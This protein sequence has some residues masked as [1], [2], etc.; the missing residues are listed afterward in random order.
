MGS[1]GN[2]LAPSYVPDKL[3]SIVCQFPAFPTESMPDP[4]NFSQV[5]N[6]SSRRF[7]CVDPMVEEKY[8]KNLRLTFS[9]HNFSELRP[10][11]AVLIPNYMIWGIEYYRN[12]N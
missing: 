2:K 7:V 4:H 5:L 8:A 9:W 11:W 6:R 10:M 1:P 3:F 12:A